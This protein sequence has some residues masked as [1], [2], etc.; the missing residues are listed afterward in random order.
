MLILHKDYDKAFQ[1]KVLMLVDIDITFA[2]VYIG[3]DFISINFQVVDIMY[4]FNVISLDF[5]LNH[6]E[7]YFLSSL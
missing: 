1:R 4:F 5:I 3:Q 6:L 7:D 2:M